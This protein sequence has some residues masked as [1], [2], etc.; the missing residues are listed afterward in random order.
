MSVGNHWSVSLSVSESGG[1]THAEAGLIMA[2]SHY[3]SGRGKARLNPADRNVVRIGEEIAIARA[4]SDL[5]HKLI[6]TAAEG[7]EDM[8]HERAQ[9]YL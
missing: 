5:A 1:E 4:L 9:L 3:L 6:H 2:D 8:T 7:I